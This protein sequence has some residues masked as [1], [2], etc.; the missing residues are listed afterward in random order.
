MALAKRQQ[1]DPIF[2][3][4]IV[5]IALFVVSTT[6]SVIYYVKYEGQ[7]TNAENTQSELEKW[8]SPSEQ[9]KGL[10]ALVGAIPPRKSAA[11][12]LIEYL[13]QLTK[14]IAGGPLS[15]TSSQIKFDAAMKAVSNNV[16]PVFQKYCSADTNDSNKMSLART[17][18]ILGD[19]LDTTTQQLNELKNNYAGL[20]EELKNTKDSHNNTVKSL[21]AQL[22]T[23]ARQVEDI[24]AEYAKL[25]SLLQQTTEQQVQS[26]RDEL[27]T[28]KA[29]NEQLKDEILKTQAVLTMTNNRMKKT[30]DQLDKI[31]P[32][33]DTNNLAYKIDGKVILFDPQTQIA[34]I[35]LGSDDGVYRGLTFAVYDK[36]LPIPKDGKG[37]AEIEVYDVDKT[38]STARLTTPHNPRNPITKDDSI[39]NL[40]WDKNQTNYFVVAGNF[41]KYGDAEKVKALIA[42]MGG[43]L[44]DDVSINTDLII[45]GTA[46]LILARPTPEQAEFNPAAMERYEASKKLYEHYK[47]IEQAAGTF[48][49]PIFNI[50][51]FFFFTGYKEQAAKPGAL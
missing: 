46:P 4:L 36:S 28:I 29:G 24:K 18:K 12:I 13:D 51:K 7:R 5:F 39:V 47:Q 23:Y 37:K 30:L 6:F 20:N 41:E 35:N 40:V 8:V 2:L 33:P 15:D 16:L 19:T 22:E 34:H 42:K 3:T 26:L 43:R 27:K 9:S 14:L 48:S 50:N 32:L 31:K 21:N 17:I 10:T 1:T 38:I 25:E 45:L 44:E 49:I 11:G